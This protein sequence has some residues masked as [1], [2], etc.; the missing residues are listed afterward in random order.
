MSKEKKVEQLA[1]KEVVLKVNLKHPAK[2][3]RLGRHVINTI[4]TKYVLNHDEQME[5][6]TAGPKKWLVV[7]EAKKESKKAE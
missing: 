6:M 3:F 7:V 4:E 1:D 2:K 5:L